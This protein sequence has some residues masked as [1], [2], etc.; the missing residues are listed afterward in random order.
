VVHISRV[1]IKNFKSFGGEPIRLNFQ[2]GFNIITGPNGSGK[3]NI[4]DAVQ[5]VLGEL[6]SK[7]MRAPDLGGLIYDGAGEDKVGRAQV[8]QVTLYFNNTD[9]GLPVDRSTVSIGRKMDRDGKSIYYL[10]GKRTSRRRVLDIIEM[11]G[12][13]P[14]GYN[15]VLQGTATRLSD[16]TPSERMNALE[17]L[18]G[19]TEYD[20]KK[21]AAKARLNEA[22]RKIEVATARIEEIKKQVNELEK[23]RNNAIAFSLLDK[24]ERRLNAYRIS[25]QLNTLDAKLAEIQGQINE[26]QEEIKGLEEER[27]RFAE[28]R[29]KAQQR[30][31]E[32][33]KEAAERGNTRLPML[34]SELVGKNTLKES[35]NGRLREIEQRKTTLQLDIQEKEAEIEGSRNEISGR[36]TQLEELEELE[37]QLREELDGRRSELATLNEKILSAR[38][39]AEQNQ[40]ELEELTESLMPMQE[41]LTGIETDVNRH[42]I[43]AE[44]IEERIAGLEERRQGYLERRG[45][46][47][48]KLK[49]YESLKDEEAKKLEDMIK[50]VEDQV[51]HQRSIRS[52]IEGANKLAKDAE[53]TITEFT[54]KKDLWRHVVTEEKAL[55][56]IVEIGEAGAID[57]YHGPFRGLLKIDLPIQRAVRSAADGWINAVVVDDLAVA[58]ENVERLKKTR[59]G[60]T[61]FIPLNRLAKPEKLPELKIKGVVGS[62][63]E[64]VR[65]DDLYAPAVYMVWGDTYIVEDADA[66]EKVAAQGYRAVTKSG[67]VFDAYGGVKGGYYRRPPDWSKLIPTD[68][69]IDNLSSTIKD[70]RRKLSTRMKELKSSGF[71]LRKFT[72][73]M[74][75]SQERVKRIDE[76]MEATRESIERLDYNMKMLL[77][78]M[79]KARA[80]LENEHALEA[81]LGERKARTLEQIEE[82]KKRIEALK[83][84]KLSDVASLELD[85]NTVNHEIGLLERRIA[86]MENDRTIQSGFVDRILSLKITEAEQDIERARGEIEALGV[87]AEEIRGQLAEVDKDIEELDGLLREVTSEVEATSRVYEGHQRTLR[88]IN[89]RIESLDRRRAE[90]ER[91]VS[92]LTLETEKVR[93]QA[94]QRLEE[95]ARLGFS[96]RV[97][98]DELGVEQV[99]RRLAQIR[100]EK[101]G[102][103]AINQLAVEHYDI[104][105]REYK[106]RSIRINGMEDEKKSILEFID[107]IEREKQDHFMN[108]YNQICENF[109]DIFGKLTGGGDG[110][111]ELQKPED[112]FSGGVDLYIQFPG[113]PMRL[114][115]GASGGERSV[116]AIAY[117]L[118]IQRFLK[119]PFYLFDEIDAHLDDLNT[120]RLAE[121]LKENAADSQ[122]LMISLK[123]VMVHN[124]DRIY[125]V[126]AQNGV[127]RVLALPMREAKVAA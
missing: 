89:N 75:D 23:Q 24:E 2:P 113:K 81:T 5:F 11:A 48:E 31:D 6:G 116:A 66:A 101:R 27:E 60:M 51:E 4:L 102:L 125:G 8:S 110:Q 14:G 98:T 30:L 20:E 49:E 62:V 85:R 109:S 100:N 93:L 37:E 99:E 63:P 61:R 25:G 121:V 79:E 115:S 111:L 117:L 127:S 10:N 120:S 39:T 53:T 56:R 92:G 114:A 126:F 118:A 65:Y 88:Q 87:E 41:S 70:L 54:A 36:N 34:R 97:E 94:E 95:L 90:T 21:A 64:L 58:K 112:P 78:A 9:R 13:T 105:K 84:V 19:I 16:L 96:D 106:Q 40:R 7:R 59:L 108:A 50:T 71:D 38:E 28:E 124:A 3:S 72:Q 91:R 69:S 68:E 86:D 32:F 122:F 103:G 57:G 18:V 123:D 73:Y 42:V 80:E 44:A 77:E 33:N 26:R 82:T 43:T 83:E 29:A 67:D 76:E 47:E 45:S 17:D 104:T 119:A 15:I 46:L 107:E 35:L 74:D 1:V 52:T 55:E 22:E 12:I